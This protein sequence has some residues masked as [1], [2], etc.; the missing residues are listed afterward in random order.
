MR[1]LLIVPAIPTHLNLLVPVAWALRAAGH[2]VSVASQPNLVGAIHSSGLT[3]VPA[4]TMLD[5]GRTLLGSKKNTATASR[6]RPFRPAFDIREAAAQK[7]TWDYLRG[8]LM[9]HAAAI[10]NFLAN[11]SM[12]ADLVDFARG[13]RPDLVIWDSAVYIGPVVARACGA[14]QVRSLS[15]PD[16]IGRMRAAFNELAANR[17]PHAGDDP[18]G[19][20]LARRLA[21]Y[22]GDFD[23]EVVLGR[24]TIDPM[25]PWMR[26]PTRA[27]YLPVRC[28]PYNGT[29]TFPRWTLEQPSRPRVCVTLGSSAGAFGL[30][31]VPIMEIIAEV[32]SLDVEVVATVSAKQLPVGAVMPENVRLFDFVPLDQLL[33]TCS[34]VVHH[35]GMGTL[36][37]ALVHGVPQLRV[38]G[39]VDGDGDRELVERGAALSLDS[40][41]L[42]PGEIA[43]AVHRLISEPTF[44]ENAARLR[45]EMLMAPSPA[46]LVP[47]LEALVR[48]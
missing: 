30:M 26:V 45:A 3:A 7:L 28:V 42:A 48:R 47:E 34:A 40:G 41:D 12:L 33:P 37:T 20:W 9:L 16:H 39:G 5:S 21:R 11:D 1:V 36:G 25:P 43:K 10:S 24:A 38:R 19:E 32:A 31:G 15:G 29:T 35:F 4:G 8:A 6:G 18:L 13:W 46:R 14:V 44:Q 22:E 2:E 17:V 27:K 23:E